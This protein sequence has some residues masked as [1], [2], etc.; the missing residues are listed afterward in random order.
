[1]S[2]DNILTVDVVSDVICPWCFVGKRRLERAIKAIPG[3]KAVR[4]RW[5]PFQLNPHM[6]AGGMNRR[7]YRSNK[8][9]N[10]QKSQELDAQVVA[11]GATEGI[12]FVGEV[13]DVDIEAVAGD[14]ELEW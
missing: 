8:F 12:A 13:I 11:V 5:L 10:W 6:P 4:V 3:G 7:E 14:V 1:M 2:D 9:G